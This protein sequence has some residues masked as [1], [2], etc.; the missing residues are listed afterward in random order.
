[1]SHIPPAMPAIEAPQVLCTAKLKN[2]FCLAKFS[3]T[4]LSLLKNGEFH[5][6]P[7]IDTCH[8]E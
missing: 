4:F 1:M 6:N 8:V 3:I 5:V 2:L 7:V